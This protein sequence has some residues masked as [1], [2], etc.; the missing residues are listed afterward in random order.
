MQAAFTL[1]LHSSEGAHDSV[2]FSIDVTQVPA[3]LV[4]DGAA[5]EHGVVRGEQT[6]I[7]FEVFNNGQETAESVT[8]QLP[9]LPR[10]KHSENI[11]GKFLLVTRIKTVPMSMR[12]PRSIGTLLRTRSAALTSN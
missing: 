4:I 7:E 6:L 10:M 9:P 3:Q 12:R 11:S 1:D 5:L 8:V 2:D